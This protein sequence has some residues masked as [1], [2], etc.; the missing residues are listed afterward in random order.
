MGELYVGIPRGAVV[1][2]TILFLIVLVAYSPLWIYLK[3]R[4]WAKPS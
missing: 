4:T 2:G 3:V 1:C